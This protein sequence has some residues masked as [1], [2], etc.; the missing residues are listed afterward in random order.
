MP[1]QAAGLLQRGP[2]SVIR[3]HFF[4]SRSCCSWLGRLD[5]GLLSG[6]TRRPIPKRRKGIDVVRSTCQAN[7]LLGRACSPKI[8]LFPNSSG[9]EFDKPGCLGFHHIQDAQARWCGCTFPQL[10]SCREHP[11]LPTRLRQGFPRRRRTGCALGS[12]QNVCNPRLAGLGTSGERILLLPLGGPEC[13]GGARLPFPPRQ[14][15]VDE[16]L[17]LQRGSVIEILVNNNRWGSGRGGFGKLSHRSRRL[18]VGIVKFKGKL[19]RDRARGGACP[20]HRN[21]SSRNRNRLRFRAPS[22]WLDGLPVGVLIQAEPRC[23]EYATNSPNVPANGICTDGRA[24]N[25][26]RRV[27][28]ARPLTRLVNQRSGICTARI[29]VQPRP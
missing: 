14:H 20:R 1:N 26:R 3:R 25:R 17:L 15:A 29:A 27:G 7:D 4:E 21:T 18:I 23:W 11:I 22:L 16:I 6:L 8:L 13:T 12:A 9:C 5:V 19:G 28:F 2:W 24:I 10:G